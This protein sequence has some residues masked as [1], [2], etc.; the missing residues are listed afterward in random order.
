MTKRI[1]LLTLALALIVVSSPDTFA[2][3]E[4]ITITCAHGSALTSA[5]TIGL[6]K[7]ANLVKERT[8]GQVIIKH[9]PAGQLYGQ[10]QALPP[11][12]KGALQMGAPL[13]YMFP[14]IEPAWGV[15]MCPMVVQDI[16]HFLRIMDTDAGKTLVKLMEQRQ[17]V[18]ILE[19][20]GSPGPGYLY[21]KRP[22]R[23]LEDWKG[24]KCRAPTDKATTQTLAAFGAN[25]IAIPRTELSSSV[26][27]GMVD[28]ILTNPLLAI[29]LA[30]PPKTLPYCTM[31]PHGEALA[32]IPIASVSMNA[33][34]W[35]DLPEHLK[36][37]ISECVTEVVV[38]YTRPQST[39]KNQGWIDKWHET[40]TVTDIFVE[41]KEWA[42]W[43]KAAA[44]VLQS[45]LVDKLSKDMYE[46]AVATR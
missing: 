31:G 11:L 23:V 35:A 41:E 14:T 7:I 1:F 8:N 43:L 25:A 2:K 4:K 37:T 18:T 24:L 36:S 39:K 27:T 17:N 33:K 29:P 34:F 10:S 40:P 42:K 26:Q 16:N 32:G 45:L 3:P 28:A 46:A 20:S 6:N 30:N 12:Q 13:T 21:S 19:W 38:D 5:T 44:P 9:F 22:I 15:M